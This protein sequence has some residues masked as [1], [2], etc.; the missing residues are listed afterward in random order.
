MGGGGG[1][2]G[3]GGGWRMEMGGERG[4]E[5]GEGDIIISF[6]ISFYFS[7]LLFLFFGVLFLLFEAQ[8]TEQHIPREIT[9]RRSRTERPRGRLCAPKRKSAYLPRNQK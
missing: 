6:F 5:R 2:R 1:M 4:E 9:R 8:L 7:Q 3:E